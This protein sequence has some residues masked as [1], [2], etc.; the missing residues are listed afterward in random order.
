MLAAVLFT[1]LGVLAWRINTAT[2]TG[3]DSS[4]W[5]WFDTH[6]SPRWH[7]DSTGAFSYLGRPL[8]VASAG[9]VF[10]VL[11]SWRAR[12]PA[13]ALMIIG[14]VGAGVIA[15]QVLKATIERVADIAPRY[16]TDYHHSFPSG[17]VTGAAT[18]LGLIAV[19]VGA[20]G[21]AAVKALLAPLVAAG[22]LTVALLALY[23]YAHTCTDVIGGMLLGGG[24]VAVG[25]ALVPAR[26]R[27][28]AVPSAG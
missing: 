2:L 20:G 19:C 15:E 12:N 7:V 27:G 21:G 28:G 16:P 1:L 24:I 6:Q 10:G 13:P 25:A 14:G 18:L 5:T 11:L 4:V 22:V 8:H 3:L 26:R 9:V 17:H 23:S